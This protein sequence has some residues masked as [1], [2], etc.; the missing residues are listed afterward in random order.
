MEQIQQ[1][2]KR[3]ISD[4]SQKLTNKNLNSEYG[5]NDKSTVA[6]HNSTG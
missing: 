2:Y 6:E 3:C 4:I 1:I 5:Q